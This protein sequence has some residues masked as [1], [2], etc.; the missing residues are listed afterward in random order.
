MSLSLIACYEGYTVQYIH[1][2]EIKLQLIS[3]GASGP[4]L[5]KVLVSNLNINVPS[6]R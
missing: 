6:L 4:L 5:Q 3:H 2:S 1:Y